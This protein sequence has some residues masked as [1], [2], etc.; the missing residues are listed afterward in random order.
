MEVPSQMYNINKKLFLMA[1]LTVFTA[2]A[3]ISGCSRAKDPSTYNPPLDEMAA[4]I[5]SAAKYENM[6]AAD[7]KMMERLYYITP[8]EIEDFRIFIAP[9]NIMVDEFAVIK[10][11]NASD[12]ASVIEKVN[13]RIDNQLKGF[14]DYLPDEYYLITKHILKTTG[15][16]IFFAVS[17]EPAKAE[18]AFDSFFENSR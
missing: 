16:Y 4:A 2:A 12:A 18:E 1:L 14:K 6:V 8:S 7:T 17:E 5:A 3:A 13:R 9:S 10:L 11:K 15:R